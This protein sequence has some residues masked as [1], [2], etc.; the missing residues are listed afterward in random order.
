LG[1]FA[2][3]TASNQ[4]RI[5]NSSVT[6]IGGYANWSNIS[7]G[8]V[9]KNIKKD[10]PGL[11]FI[12]KLT[13]VTYNLDLNAVD[14]IIQQPPVNGRDQNIFQIKHSAD[15][16]N[17]RT[18]K[19]QIVYT[20]FVAQDVEAAAKSINYNFSGIDEPKNSHDLYGLRYAEFVV[21]LVKAVQEQ[22]QQIEDLKKE[23][24]EIKA[25]LLKLMEIISKK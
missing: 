23:N 17:S 22:Q 16:K 11:A 15:E 10:V 20:G 4:V 14:D 24:L 7:D 6:S 5:G 18:A 12:T 2:S 13:P 1:Y 19:Q 25:R 3:S 21:P 8:R 9:K